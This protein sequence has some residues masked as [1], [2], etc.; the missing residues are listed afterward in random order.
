MKRIIC[1]LFSAII[2]FG[3]VGCSANSAENKTSKSN[4]KGVADIL[5]SAA[6]AQPTT[7]GSV[8]VP[9][10][11]APADNIQY[12]ELEYDAEVDLTEFNS[13][14]VYS[15]VAAMVSTPEKY[16]GKTVKMQGTFDVYTDIN[17]GTYY[18][19]CIIKDATACCSSGIEF[20]WKGEHKFPDDYPSVGTPVTVGGVFETYPEGDKNY[21]R[22]KEADVVFGT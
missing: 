2:I 18:Y 7:V 19:A 22:L 8:T 20:S 14:M 16:I 13:N 12:P 5:S 21:C 6:E 10:T 11:S 15:E 17:T 3:S 9:A 4:Q 1:V